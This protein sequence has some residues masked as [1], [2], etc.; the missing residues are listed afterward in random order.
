MGGT[1]SS[2][3]V[4]PPL[5]WLFCRSCRDRAL[6]THVCGHIWGLDPRRSRGK[7][8]GQLGVPTPCIPGM[9]LVCGAHLPCPAQG[10]V[11]ALTRTPG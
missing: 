1:P 2:M 9:C 11:P 4:P 6:V 3:G 10:G 7:F 5:F 8:H